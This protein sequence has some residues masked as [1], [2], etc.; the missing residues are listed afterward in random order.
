[1][2]IGDAIMTGATIRKAHAA[3]PGKPICVGPGQAIWSEVW[4]GL[5][6]SRETKPGAVWIH[7][8]GK[9]RP[10]IDY[11]KSDADHFHYRPEFRAEPGWIELSAAEK[12]ISA[13]D[14]FIYLEPTVKGSFSGNKDWGILNWQQ[15]ADRFPPHTFLQGRGHRLDRA[16][17]IDTPTIRH[18][19]ALLAKARLFVG[20]DGALHHAAAALGIPAVVVWG[21]VASPENLGYESHTNLWSGTKPCGSNDTCGHCASALAAITPS[22]VVAA[23]HEALETRRTT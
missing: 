13:P 9:H 23:I 1:M 14:S 17:Q 8:Y 6:V 5:P 4:E 21:G 12:N 11:E 2:G 7:D 19:F 10:Y 16:M 15:V 3:H 22:M 18:A 20:T